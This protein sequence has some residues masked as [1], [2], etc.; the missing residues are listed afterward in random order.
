MRDELD[1]VDTVSSPAAVT[2][3]WQTLRRRWAIV[4][5]VSATVFAGAAFSTFTKTPK[6]QS[7]TLIL[8][9]DNTSVPVVPTSDTGNQSIDESNKELAT[10]IQI[11]KSRPLVSR[12][13]KEL[14]GSYKDLSVEQVA[15]NLSIRQAE[16]AG[17]L[18]VSYTDT[19]PKR[20]KSVLETLGFTYVNYSSER[21]RS[22]ATNAIRLIVAK[23]PEAK[24]ALNESSSA[25]KDFRKRY[26]I[27]DP[28]SYS[29]VVSQSQQSLQQQAT[30]VKTA[31]DQTQRQYQELLRQMA[32]VSQAPG[33]IV[34]DAVLSQDSSYQKLVSQ[35]QEIESQYAQESVRF[36]DDHPKIRDLKMRRERILSLLQ[37][38]AERVL[39]SKASQVVGKEVVSGATQQSLAN[40]L[41]QAQTTLAVQSARLNS[42]RRAQAE[43]A[44]RFQQI[45]YLQQNYARLQD[46]Y[47]LNSQTFN[48]LLQKLQELQIIE[49]QE[50]SPWR[51]LEPPYLPSTPTSPDVKHDLLLGLVGGGLLGVGAAVLLERL[52]KRVKGVDEVKQMTGIPLLWVVPKVDRKVLASIDGQKS[53]YQRYSRSPFTESLRSLAL[54]LNFLGSSRNVKTF[55]FTSASHAEGKTTIIYNLGLMLA[56]LGQRV[57]VVDADMYKPTIHQLCQQSNAFG[58]STA[59]ATNHPWRELIHSGSSDKLDVMT[60]GPPAQNP[61]A[62]L[63]SDK[64]KK[65]LDEWRQA[66]DYVL[67]DTSPIIGFTEA[68]SIASTVDGVVLVVAIEVSTR[69]AITRAMEILSKSQYKCNIVGFVG[70]LLKENDKRFYQSDSSDYGELILDAI[71]NHPV[72]H[73]KGLLWR[74][75]GIW[76]NLRRLR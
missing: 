53:L 12:A 51:V 46:Q 41:L 20:V 61:V 49:A 69:P 45:P 56:D 33:T 43:A 10:E 17:I 54:N 18:I 75:Q 23:L 8:V 24:Q 60:S 70:N 57:L 22:R 38:Q 50:T 21:K 76:N 4:I 2:N 47:K 7:E 52:D 25:I 71:S 3:L 15:G 72:I 31:L 63:V 55:A 37:R 27:A 62:L 48:N 35:L 6:Y 14:E 58:L 66:Y 59:I 30:E 26:G 32:Q 65:L 19:D 34:A 39:G 11:L 40:Q 68:Q 28:D 64:M 36:R 1:R 42:I 73:G 16:K 13:V 74:V 29:A 9:N 44:E 5:A 67:L